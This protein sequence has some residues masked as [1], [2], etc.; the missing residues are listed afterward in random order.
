[1]GRDTELL[2]VCPLMRE[3]LFDELRM[4]DDKDL[5]EIINLRVQQ[6][7][8]LKSEDRCQSMP[9]SMPS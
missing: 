1:M 7:Q 8:R 5:T 3:M 6:R 9:M 4:A 2:V